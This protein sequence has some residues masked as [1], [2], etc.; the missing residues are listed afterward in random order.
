[1]SEVSR[2]ES[3]LLATCYPI[4]WASGTQV[5]LD[6]SYI[7][8]VIGYWSDCTFPSELSAAV[9]NRQVYSGL[10][11]RL[12]L[13][14]GT[15]GYNFT[16]SQATGFFGIEI[17]QHFGLNLVGRAELEGWR[18]SSPLLVILCLV[19]MDLEI[20]NYGHPQVGIRR[21]LLCGHHYTEF[22]LC[23]H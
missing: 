18:I 13:C 1:M 17:S 6:S 19:L 8:R 4:W 14:P 7:G 20:K 15:H 10:L 22:I 11:P 21:K 12:G 2:Q 16:I 23:I 5:G 3:W 9:F